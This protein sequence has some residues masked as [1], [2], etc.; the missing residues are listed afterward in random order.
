MMSTHV[1]QPLLPAIRGCMYFI[2]CSVDIKCLYLKDY[3]C[4]ITFLDGCRVC[5]TL[6]LECH[7][8][9]VHLGCC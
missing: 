5:M 2:I 9:V 6:S 7:D 1:K 4:L 8:C 3:A